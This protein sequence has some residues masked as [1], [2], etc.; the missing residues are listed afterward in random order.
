MSMASGRGRPLTMT[1]CG[2]DGTITAENGVADNK[3]TTLAA[4]KA[5]DSK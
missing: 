4:G 1:T 2:N 5:T 3:S